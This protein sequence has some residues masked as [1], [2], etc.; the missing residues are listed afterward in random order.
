MRKRHWSY[1][2]EKLRLAVLQRDNYECQIRGPN[3]TGYAGT[4]DH[5]HP[6]AWGGAE[7]PDNLRAAC[8]ACNMGKGARAPR[9]SE[10]S[11]FLKERRFSTAPLQ[12]VSL[13]GL[14]AVEVRDYSTKRP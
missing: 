3:C 10:A 9:A 2:G 6:R 5:I 1:R 14:Y 7:H 8:K 13:R 4:V 12:K 11:A